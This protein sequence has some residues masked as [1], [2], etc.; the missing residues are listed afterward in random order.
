VEPRD[1]HPKVIELLTAGYRAMP[2]REKIARAFDMSRAVREMAAARIRREHPELDA[3][4]V[5]V[6]VAVLCYGDELVR[7]ALAGTTPLEES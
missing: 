5:Q 6:R 3:R 2:A 7:R 4:Q 1:T